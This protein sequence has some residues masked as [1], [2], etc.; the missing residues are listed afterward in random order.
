M[1]TMRKFIYNP[2]GI[3]AA[4]AMLLAAASYA[5]EAQEEPADEGETIEEI[6]VVAPKPGDRK[7]VDR[8]YEDP[9]RAQLLIDFYKMQEDQKELK[10]RDAAIEESP[11][12]FSWGY[13][14]SDEYRLRNEMAL[15]EL[16]SER[17]QPATVFSIKF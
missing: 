11:S 17:T 16:P 14:P 15:Q 13:D 9:V 3:A 8:E 12:R 6:I 5:Q 2:I 1:A 10:W 4:I 7:R